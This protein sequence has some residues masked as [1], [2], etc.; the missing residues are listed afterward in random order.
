MEFRVH[1]HRFDSFRS[2]NMG[3]KQIGTAVTRTKK[4]I[5]TWFTWNA[6][7]Q[8]CCR[9][10]FDRRQTKDHATIGVFAKQDTFKQD[11]KNN[12]YFTLLPARYFPKFR[13]KNRIRFAYDSNEMND[14]N[15]PLENTFKLLNNQNQI[16]MFQRKISAH[17]NADDRIKM[18]FYE[19]CLWFWIIN[20]AYARI[21]MPF[22]LSAWS[23]QLL[24]QDYTQDAAQLIAREREQ[25]K[26]NN[27][28]YYFKMF[29]CK[30]ATQAVT[31]P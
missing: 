19:F 17:S 15:Q 25:K 2:S 18:D 4:Q 21:E 3:N 31:L 20:K 24:H 13:S 29:P 28:F 30:N 16:E 7:A 23:N 27:S 1:T 8:T 5:T 26:R 6:T 12:E 9:Y 22:S 14:N 10:D 11:H